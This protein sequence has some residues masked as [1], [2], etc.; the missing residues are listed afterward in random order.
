MRAPWGRRPHAVPPSAPGPGVWPGCCLQQGLG[1]SWGAHRPEPRGGRASGSCDAQQ[2][3]GNARGGEPKTEPGHCTR[4]GQGAHNT[5][6]EG[7]GPQSA[8]DFLR[9][10]KAH[11]DAPARPKGS[12]L[13]RSGR[14]HCWG[15]CVC[16]RVCD[17]LSPNLLSRQLLSSPKARKQQDGEV[18]AS[19]P[20]PGSLHGLV[21]R[22]RAPWE[23]LPSSSRRMF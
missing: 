15:I 12:P 2:Q 7:S 17:C 6:Q 8:V 4:K 22:R 1:A 21:S 9:T 16:L 10:Q 13:D 5:L 14:P 19:T 3:Q 23:I 11:R 20:H 18:A